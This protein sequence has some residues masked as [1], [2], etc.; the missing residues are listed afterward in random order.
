L[1]AEVATK[2]D[3]KEDGS[4]SFPTK[5]NSSKSINPDFRPSNCGRRKRCEA[6]NVLFHA[7]VN[8]ENYETCKL[9]SEIQIIMK[10]EDKVMMTKLT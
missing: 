8:L 7:N 6:W 9:R 1:A 3:K 10:S 2:T 4:G 5:I